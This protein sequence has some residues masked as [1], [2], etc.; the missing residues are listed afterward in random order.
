MI[1]CS[2]CLGA[3]MWGE[4]GNSV[5]VQEVI[6]QDHKGVL[7]CAD[8]LL[9]DWGVGPHHTNYVESYNR[10]RDAITKALLRK[11]RDEDQ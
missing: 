7:V 11:L 2:K 10:L 4:N 9:K 5:D 8:H 6:S 3:Y 1:L